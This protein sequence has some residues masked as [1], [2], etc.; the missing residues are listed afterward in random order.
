MQQDT[1]QNNIQN[2]QTLSNSYKQ[3][4]KITV[5]NIPYDRYPLKRTIYN[6]LKKLSNKNR[7]IL[8]YPKKNAIID[9]VSIVPEITTKSVT[10]NNIIHSFVENGMVDFE[11]NRFPDF[12][13]ILE[14]RKK[15]TTVEGY[16]LCE[17]CFTYCSIPCIFKL[18]EV[19]PQQSIIVLR[20]FE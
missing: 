9:F 10:R 19:A 20:T 3:W 13:N 7:L 1:Q 18:L 12:K 8:K 6:S 11:N 5:R 4:K 16:K 15:D 17:T 2:Q 14:T